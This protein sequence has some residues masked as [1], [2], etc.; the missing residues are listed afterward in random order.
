MRRWRAASAASASAMP[1]S[2]HCEVVGIGAT[3]PGRVGG[4]GVPNQ[5]LTG[6]A[7][8]LV[9]PAAS[10]W[11]LALMPRTARL[12]RFCVPPVS[13]LM[14]ALMLPGVVDSMRSGLPAAPVSVR[15]DC[16]VCVLPAANC[17]SLPVVLVMLSA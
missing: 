4:V 1:I 6:P 17:T 8:W 14:S 3:P 10:H 5:R 15:A 16:T 7:P 11:P 13:R 9:W 12:A 2:V